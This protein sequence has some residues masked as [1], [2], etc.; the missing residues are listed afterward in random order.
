[1]LGD[2]EFSKASDGVIKEGPRAPLMPRSFKQQSELL[3]ER[4]INGF[5]CVEM[6][7]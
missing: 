3:W 1:M 7:A 5:G 2:L 6:P 4:L